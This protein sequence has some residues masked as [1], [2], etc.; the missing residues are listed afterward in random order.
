MQNVGA[1]PQAYSCTGSSADLR[2]IIVGVLGSFLYVS[3]DGGLS[4][5]QE[6]G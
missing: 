3:T 6:L 5:R 2:I 1:G 4:W